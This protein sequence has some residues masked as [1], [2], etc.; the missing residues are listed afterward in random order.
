[1]TIK[2]AMIR[3]PKRFYDDHCERDPRIH[4]KED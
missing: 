1:M 4:S 3:I 2:T